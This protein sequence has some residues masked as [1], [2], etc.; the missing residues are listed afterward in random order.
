MKNWTIREDI[1]SNFKIVMNALLLLLFLLDNTVIAQNVKIEL[2]D[3][4][5][6]ANLFQLEGEKAS[7]ID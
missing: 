5:E 6:Y 2:N 3:A 4:P 1:I 7:K